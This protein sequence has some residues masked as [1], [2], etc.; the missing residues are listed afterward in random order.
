MHNAYISVLAETGLAGIVTLVAAFVV[1]RR[2]LRDVAVT[3]DGEDRA[4]FDTI[5]LLLVVVLVW[6]NDDPLFGA[7][8]ETV[9]AATF[10]GL[11]ASYTVSDGDVA[12]P[13]DVATPIDE[14]N[15]RRSFASAPR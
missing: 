13:A 4:V 2:R 6:W 14:V 8:P 3:L 5:R 11:L 1:V 15:T 7:Q 10:L 9:L 12:H